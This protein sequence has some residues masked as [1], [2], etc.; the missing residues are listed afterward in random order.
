MKEDRCEQ[1]NNACDC[2]P[3]Q[4]ACQH[5]RS[6]VDAVPQRSNRVFAADGEAEVE[7]VGRRGIR[8]YQSVARA[9]IDQ[10]QAARVVEAGHAQCD[11][12]RPEEEVGD[13][14]NSAT[15]EGNRLEQQRQTAGERYGWQ[16]DE[17]KRRP[18]LP[19]SEAVSLGA[20]GLHRQ[21]G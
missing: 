7:V 18:Q 14:S 20:G 5:L 21:C 1:G 19:E 11:H 9:A 13:V 4:T 8:R 12:R 2:D 15:Q 17:D 3:E 6:P 16:G 10:L